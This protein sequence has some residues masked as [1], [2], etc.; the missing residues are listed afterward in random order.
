MLLL[1]LCTPNRLPIALFGFFLVVLVFL[2]LAIDRVLFLD[3][4]LWRRCPRPPAT[5][6]VLDQILEQP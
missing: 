6:K 4:G 3:V 5:P 2:F 1:E